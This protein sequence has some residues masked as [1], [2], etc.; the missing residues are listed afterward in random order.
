[1]LFTDVSYNILTLIFISLSHCYILTPY[2]FLFYQLKTLA[3]FHLSVSPI[4][5]LHF[6]RFIF[7]LFLFFH[8]INFLPYYFFPFVSIHF[9]YLFFSFI[10]L[11]YFFSYIFSSQGQ[12]ILVLFISPFS[13]VSL[14]SATSF[15]FHHAFFPLPLLSPLP[16]PLLSPLN[17]VIITSYFWGMASVLLRSIIL[18]FFCLFSYF[19]FLLFLVFFCFLLLLFLLSLYV[20]LF[21]L[22]FQFVSL[23]CSLCSVFLLV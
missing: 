3:H 22:F 4:N 23:P 2:S 9:Q 16:P 19:L 10:I 11:T 13:L 20:Y 15:L 21:L 18:L 1:M 7:N 6:I 8:L 17:T 12:T 14:S 5:S